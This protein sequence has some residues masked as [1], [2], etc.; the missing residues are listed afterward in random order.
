MEERLTG[1]GEGRRG[2]VSKKEKKDT[3][4]RRTIRKPIC[5]NNG[6]GGI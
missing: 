5:T 6:A 4:A 3:G 2:S 1:G